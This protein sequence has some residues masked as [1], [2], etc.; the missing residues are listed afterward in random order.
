MLDS[1]VEVYRV[2]EREEIQ[3]N[4]GPAV[5]CTVRFGYFWCSHG[6]STRPSAIVFTGK[7]RSGS[8]QRGLG[9]NRWRGTSD[10]QGVGTF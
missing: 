1:I 5:Y 8:F 7:S 4:D 2:F 6:T 10:T 3:G 9:E